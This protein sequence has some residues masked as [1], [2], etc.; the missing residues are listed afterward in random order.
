MGLVGLIGGI[1]LMPST[2]VL[3]PSTLMI[4]HI[5]ATTIIREH[6]NWH[7]SLS[8]KLLDCSVVMIAGF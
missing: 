3:T 2:W 1:W 8:R 7:A 6:R 4:I 5:I